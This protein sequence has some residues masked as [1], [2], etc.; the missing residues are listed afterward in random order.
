MQPRATRTHNDIFYDETDKKGL[1]LF[2]VLFL[3]YEKVERKKWNVI[4]SLKKQKKQDKMTRGVALQE[5]NASSEQ[6]ASASEL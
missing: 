4:K 3:N 6:C 5:R 2:K 1:V